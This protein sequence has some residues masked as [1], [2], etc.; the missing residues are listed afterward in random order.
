MEVSGVVTIEELR[1]QG[2]TGSI[3]GQV[4]SS[5]QLDVGERECIVVCGWP[6]VG[7]STL[8]MIKHIYV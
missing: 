5:V 3:Q 8:R 2:S 6:E 4:S 1:L 7:D